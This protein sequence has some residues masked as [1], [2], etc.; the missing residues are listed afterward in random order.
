MGSSK[1]ISFSFLAC[2]LFLMSGTSLA[3]LTPDFYDLTCPKVFKVVGSVVKAAVARE[4]RMG[5]SLLRLHFHDCFVNGCDASILL[6]DT[7]S[8]RGEKTANPNVNSARGFE[9]IDDIKSNVE[10]VCPGVVS[11]ADILAITALES[12]LALGGPFWRVNLGRRDSKSASFDVAN[13]NAIPPP[14]SSLDNLV[15]TFQAVGLTADDMVALA[16]AHTIG[17]ARCTNFRPHVYNDT[18][19]DLLFASLR[20][21]NCPV[22]N[23]LGDNNLAP[24]DARTSDHFDNSYYNNLL[25]NQ[26]LLHSDMQLL[27]GGSTDWLVEEY[28]RNPIKFNVDFAAAMIKMGDISPLTGDDGEIR[29]NCRVPN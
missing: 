3:Q 7:S 29:R 17:Q 5:A 26:G 22:P 27:S 13:G 4:N 1:I 2:T 10:R 15:R 9:V 14:T 11:C 16:G 6:D 23:G 8:F 21:I 20:R 28:S 24:L 25:I 19:V 18:N 12:V